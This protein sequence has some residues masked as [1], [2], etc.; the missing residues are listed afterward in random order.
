MTIGHTLYL[1]TP[2]P[3][4]PALLLLGA[5]AALL[6]IYAASRFA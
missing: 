3:V 2:Q 4:H 5:L 1:S 6:T